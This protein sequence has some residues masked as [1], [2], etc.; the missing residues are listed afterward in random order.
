MAKGKY[1]QWL[2]TDNL[3]RLEA[4]A[5]D[6]LTDLQIA[7]N[8]GINVATL[9]AYKTKYHEI[10]NALKKGKEVIDIEVENS[11]LKRA[12]GYRYTETTRELL[13]SKTTGES[14]LVVTKTIT[15]EVAPDV[16]AQIIWL[17]NRKPDKWRDKP[18]AEPTDTNN[19]AHTDIVTALMEDSHDHN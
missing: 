14:G 6:G 8:M 5:R 15:K 17:K 13:T 18:I 10:S 12:L 11:L 3:T 4:W 7:T 1:Q 16:T 2:E 19:K 9:Y